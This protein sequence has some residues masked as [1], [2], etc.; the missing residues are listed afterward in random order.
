[1]YPAMH[2]LGLD[3][4]KPQAR[5]SPVSKEHAAS[6]QLFV[7]FYVEHPE[8]RITVKDG[9]RMREEFQDVN[10]IYG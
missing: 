10:N 7:R 6:C 3:E 4:V 9:L 2:F 8:I 5:Y 1:M